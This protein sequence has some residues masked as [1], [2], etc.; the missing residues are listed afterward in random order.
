MKTISIPV[1]DELYE[2]Y[3]KNENTVNAALKSSIQN[4]LRAELPDRMELVKVICRAKAPVCNWR[5]MEIQ[6]LRGSL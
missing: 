1:S 2:L 5:D 4:E 3:L 6:I